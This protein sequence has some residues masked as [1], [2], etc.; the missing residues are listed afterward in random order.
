[1]KALLLKDVFVLSKQM[2]F[3]LFIIIFFS[4]APN[5][6]TTMFAVAYAAML[7]MTALAYDERSKWPNLAMM[8]PYSMKSL[9]LSKYIIGYIGIGVSLVLSII[10]ETIIHIA[11]GNPVTTE[12]YL[13][14]VLSVCVGGI[15]LPVI[16]PLLF[17]FGVE[18]GRIFLFIVM[19]AMVGIAYGVVKVY[20]ELHLLLSL[21]MIAL[22]LFIITVLFN[23]ISY[24][25]S[26]FV[27]NKNLT[28]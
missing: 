11:K 18:K 27:Y 16:M 2:K 5:N 24:R 4:C 15:L 19:G 6:A 12:L 10:S 8:M 7:P 28:K 21:Q 20:T 26:L 25:I 14:E 17:R 9:V 13:A 3:Y 23:L 1:M 22:I